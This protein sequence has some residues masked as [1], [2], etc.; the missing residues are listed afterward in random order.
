MMLAGRVMI[1]R[2]GAMLAEM[3]K[4]H[5][6]GCVLPVLADVSALR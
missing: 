6:M 4:E 3:A 5:A 1:F 2:G